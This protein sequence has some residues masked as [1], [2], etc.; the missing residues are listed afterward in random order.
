MES[1]NDFNLFKEISQLSIDSIG[2]PSEH[3]QRRRRKLATG[4]GGAGA[5]TT[6]PG[7]PMIDDCWT[8]CNVPLISGLSHERAFRG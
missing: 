6:C 1:A 2:A 8:V 3:Q 7:L 5:V 4:L